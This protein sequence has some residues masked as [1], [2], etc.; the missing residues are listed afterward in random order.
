[1]PGKFGT[2]VGIAIGILG[3]GV[4]VYL[5]TREPSDETRGLLKPRSDPTPVNACDEVGAADMLA[6]V[7]SN[8]A[9]WSGD[10]PYR[11]ITMHDQPR[12]TVGRD[13]DGFYV[14]ALVTSEDQRVI[15][16]I[17]R[18]AFVVNPNNYFEIELTKGDSELVVRDQYGNEA[19]VVSMI[20][21]RAVSVRGYF[22][23]RNHLLTLSDDKVEHFV[24]DNSGIRSKFRFRESCSRNVPQMFIVE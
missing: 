8:A 21:W 9:V 17:K 20:N 24:I 11:I 3:I 1:M 4:S 5:A 10:G 6:V 18:N 23:S 2:I 15:A 22:Y 14:D 7:G 12:L 13:D 19:L 16:E